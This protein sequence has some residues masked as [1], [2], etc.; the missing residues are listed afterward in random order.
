MDS[1]GQGRIRWIRVRIGIL[2]VAM[3]AGFGT[4]ASGAWN[5]G[6]VRRDELR[7]LAE[8]QYKRRITIP[9]RRGMITDRH[10][11]EMAVEVEVRAIAAL[12]GIGEEYK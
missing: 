9:A 4:V 6:V 7:S 11:E 8:E 3:L 10:G 2:I 1:I 12:P 5:L